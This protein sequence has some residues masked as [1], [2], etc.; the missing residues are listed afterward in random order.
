VAIT[1]QRTKAHIDRLA[2]ILE[3]AVAAE[4][5]AAPTSGATA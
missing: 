5:A 2:L 3:A 4:R 1:E